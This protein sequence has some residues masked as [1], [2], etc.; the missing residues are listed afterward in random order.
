[1]SLDLRDEVESSASTVSPPARPTSSVSPEVAP[2]IDREWPVSAPR[3]ATFPL[4]RQTPKRGVAARRWLPFEFISGAFLV[5]LV[6]L[7]AIQISVVRG[8]SMQ[9][10]L[11][12]GDRLII[13]R[14]SY[15]VMD[16][17]R[18]DVVVLRSPIDEGVD[19]VKRVI[20]LPGDRVRLDD[21]HVFVNDEMVAESFAHVVDHS[22]MDEVS[23]PEGH[24]FL[25]GDNRPVSCDSREFGLVRQ[26][27]L[28]GK[29]RARF[30]PPSRFA[31]F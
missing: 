27:R 30:W 4:S 12:D 14:I 2:R 23:V 19:Y 28:R 16:V 10:S 24:Y 18:F 8:H 26:E 13:D 25:L 7:F 29:V 22:M 21:G 31:V 15:S 9:P 1:M 5:V 6:Y 17:S 3:V 11:S 20:G